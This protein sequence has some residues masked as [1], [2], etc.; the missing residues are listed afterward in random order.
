MIRFFKML[1]KLASLQITEYDLYMSYVKNFNPYDFPCPKCSS[2]F[3]GWTRHD[4]YHRYIISFENG[5]SRAYDV[6]TE[7]YKCSSCD[8]TH[9]VI[10]EFLV[11]YR[12]YSLFFILY[13][14]KEY[15]T[16]SLT[17]VKMCEKYSIAISTFYS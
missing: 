2:K 9:A 4:H 14:M 7:R 13:V 1:K 6:A 17:V 11:P 5:K 8:H 3:P 12:S 16:K 15:F 10:P